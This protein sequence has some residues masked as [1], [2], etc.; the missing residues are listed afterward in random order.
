MRAN[1]TLLCGH[2]AWPVKIG[3]GKDPATSKYGPTVIPTAATVEVAT[4]ALSIDTQRWVSIVRYNGRTYTL[5]TNL[6]ATPD[7]AFKSLKTKGA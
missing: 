5:P 7:Q 1:M 2:L 3:R 6:L 4:Y